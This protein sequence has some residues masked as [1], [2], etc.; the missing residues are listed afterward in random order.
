MISTLDEL[1][2]ELGTGWWDVIHYVV[3]IF[4]LS[5]PASQALGGAFYA[6]A[7]DYTCV[8]TA[9]SAASETGA[10]GG[11]GGGG[12]PSSWRLKDPAPENST[13]LNRCS[14][15]MENVQTGEVIEESCSEWLFDNSTFATTV[16]SEFQLTCDRAYLRATYQSIYMLGMFIGALISGFA[17]DRFGRKATLVVG[18]LSFMI[19][20]NV[21]CLLPNL[22]VLLFSRFLL[23]FTMPFISN[24]SYILVV[25]ISEPRLRPHLGILMMLPWAFGMMILGGIAYLIREWRWLQFTVSIPGV[26]VLPFLW[27][28]DESPRW[29]AVTGRH[30]RALE[31]LKKAARLNRTSLPGN[32]KVLAILRESKEEESVNPRQEKKGIK[33]MIQEQLASLSILL[34]T[35]KLRRTTLA[36]YCS[37]VIVNMSYYGLSL[38]GGNLSNDPFVFMVLSGL[39]EVPAYSLTVPLVAHFGRRMPTLVS[40]ALSGVALLAIA[41]TPPSHGWLVMTLAM[42]GKVCIASAYQILIFYSTELF[43]TEVRSRGVGTC[44]MIS[45]LGSIV[46]PFINEILGSV[47]PWAPSA[48]FG[49]TA[50][51]AGLVMLMLPETM[52]VA[53]PETVAELEARDMP[54]KKRSWLRIPTSEE[55]GGDKQ[56]EVL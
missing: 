34:R 7:V 33:V 38:S 21:S 31:V 9:P 51:V 47:Y 46:S 13:A 15:L 18:L 52:G 19:L 24:I 17:A 5:L 28:M 42:V 55:K 41:P 11:G 14:Y 40:F 20:S 27:M 53:L 44:F 29:L 3:A 36:L 32:E 16:T 1:L 37:Y 2:A 26:L 10:E 8:P 39:M 6:P 25:E 22:S 45:R 54:S 43:P 49:A 48:V 50:F 56:Q 4:C 12:G 35:P 23:G 30:E